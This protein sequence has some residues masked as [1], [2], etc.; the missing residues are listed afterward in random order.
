MFSTVELC[1]I[2][3]LSAVD[4]KPTVH[5]HFDVYGRPWTVTPWTWQ[6]S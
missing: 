3:S 4:E 2:L 6:P 5:Q 1:A